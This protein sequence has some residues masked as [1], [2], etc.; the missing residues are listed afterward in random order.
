MKNIKLTIELVPRTAWFTNLRSEVT[1]D[2]WDEIRRN[3]YKKANYRCEICS[4]IGSKWPVECHEIWRYD[5]RTNIQKL[6]GTVAL[7]PNCHMVKH[8][9]LAGIRGLRTD[10]IAHLQLV[11]GWDIDKAEKYVR[12]AFAVWHVRSN[13][14]W[15]LDVAWLKENFTWGWKYHGKEK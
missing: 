4:G 3:A 8:I 15:S 1:K 10:A 7:C 12:D 11:N 9:G 14:K 6:V 5:D 13:Y 2:E